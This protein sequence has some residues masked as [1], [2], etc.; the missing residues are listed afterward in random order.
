MCVSGSEISKVAA[1]LFLRPWTSL[2]LPADIAGPVAGLLIAS[3][4]D[5]KL[6]D[7]IS[8]ESR[9]V[10]IEFKGR[11]FLKDTKRFESVREA[12]KSGKT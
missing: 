2:L 11:A 5:Q 9:L 3:Q 12:N 10:V 1:L 8:I 4:V 6:P 7:L